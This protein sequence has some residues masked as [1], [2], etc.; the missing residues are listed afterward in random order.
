MSEHP[1]AAKPWLAVLLIGL[2]VAISA[3]SAAAVEPTPVGDAL[4]D[5]E[6]VLRLLTVAD[7]E[8][9]GADGG[10]LS[11]RVED[12]RAMAEG[13]DPEQVREIRSWYG[14]LFETVD[15]RLSLTL[16]VVEFDSAE[17]AHRQLDIVESGP[18]F[19][20]MADPIGDRSVS[21]GADDGIGA[22]LAFVSARRLVTM[23]SAA[24]AGVDPLVDE[25]Q[26]RQLA[27]VVERRL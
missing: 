24:A 20:A 1:G 27:R 22:A 16:T 3:C 5:E 18:A 14:L 25:G 8:A 6:V 19:E 26:L 9:V 21:A 7:I 11:P 15:R 13:V 2:T 17:R 10:A 12:V 23:H 4:I